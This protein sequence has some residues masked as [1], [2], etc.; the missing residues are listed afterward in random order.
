MNDELK[1]IYGR[2]ESRCRAV[3]EQVSDWPCQKG[4]D[5]CCRR[6][7][8]PPRATLAEW[9]SLLAAFARLEPLVQ[10]AIR[11]RVS[12]MVR[13]SAQPQPPRHY[14]CPMLDRQS[15]A[16][17]VYEGR[18]SAC[19]TYGYYVSRAKG[20]WCERVR[21]LAEEREVLLGNEDAVEAE[22]S[23]LGPQQGIAEAFGIPAPAGPRQDGEGP[24]ESSSR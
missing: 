20:A 24:D 13:F 8:E 9:E 12:E 2:I 21:L 22:L 4:C 6:L 3:S 16:C 15:G 5:A 1:T 7:A 19:R 14:V 10:A 23:L 18:L 11:E 17:L